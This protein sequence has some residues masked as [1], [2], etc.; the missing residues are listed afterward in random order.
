MGNDVLNAL[1]TAF[2]AVIAALLLQ[3]LS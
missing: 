1:N 3:V 2:G